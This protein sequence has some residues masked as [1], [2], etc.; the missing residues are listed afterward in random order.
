MEAP[1]FSRSLT[2]YVDVQI[3]ASDMR[4]N[5]LWRNIPYETLHTLKVKNSFNGSF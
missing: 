2:F 1:V 3:S 5:N 4:D